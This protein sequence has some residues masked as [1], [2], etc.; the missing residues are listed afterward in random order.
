M[1]SLRKKALNGN[2]CGICSDHSYSISNMKVLR[3]SEVLLMILF[4]LVE[5]AKI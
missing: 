4:N 2:I 5:I 3:F 1:V